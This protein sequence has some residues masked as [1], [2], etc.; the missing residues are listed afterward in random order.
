MAADNN[1]LATGSL[2]TVESTVMGVAGSAPAFSMAVTT[3]VI[4]AAVGPLSVGSVLYCGLIMFGIMLAFIH[5]NH[6]TSHAG[7]TYA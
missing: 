1:S 3:A 6:T 4:V 7:A 2:G 5:L